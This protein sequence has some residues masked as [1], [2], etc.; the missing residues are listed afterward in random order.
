[1]VC[2]YCVSNLLCFAKL[3]SAGGSPSVSD[4]WFGIICLTVHSIYVYKK[5]SAM[6]P[7]PY[8]GFWF[9]VFLFFPHKLLLHSSQ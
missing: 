7:S 6:Q 5:L 3:L 2:H 9:C 1:M 8:V 4:L